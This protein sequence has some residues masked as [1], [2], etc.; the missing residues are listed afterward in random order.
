M[1]HRRNPY[2]KYNPKIAY[3]K[4]CSISEISGLGRSSIEDA[5]KPP[6]FI[7]LSVELGNTTTKCI[8]TATDLKIGRAYLIRKSVKLTRVSSLPS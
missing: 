3:S 6:L 7:V 5:Y 4:Y 8:L 2:D 1:L